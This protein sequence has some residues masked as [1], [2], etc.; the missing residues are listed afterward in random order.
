MYMRHSKKTDAS[1]PDSHPINY[2]NVT[3]CS[4]QGAS[5]RLEHLESVRQWILI[6]SECPRPGVN[7][8]SSSQMLCQKTIQLRPSRVMSEYEVVM[9]AIRSGNACAVMAS[10]QFTPQQQARLGRLS[11]LYRCEIFFTR[12]DHQPLH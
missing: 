9:K 8:L 11:K 1:K 12:S 6:T 5:Q 10:D 4:L 7:L 2:D 3:Y